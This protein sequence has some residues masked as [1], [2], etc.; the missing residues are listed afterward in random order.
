MNFAGILRGL[1]DTRV[2][3]L[4]TLFCYWGVAIPLG[5]YLV[6]YTDMGAKGVWIALVTA[7]GLASVLLGSRL[8]QQQKVLKRQWG[9]L[10]PV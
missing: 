1:Q 9:L 2:P 7:L 8:W 6:R 10:Q 4:M 5:T 3:M